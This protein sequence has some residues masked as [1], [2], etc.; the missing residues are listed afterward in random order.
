V[1][2]YV[3][4]F[5]LVSAALIATDRRTAE[6]LPNTRDQDRWSGR[7]SQ[8]GAGYTLAGFSGGAYLLGKATGNRHIQEAGWLAIEAIAHTQVVIFGV[9][10]ITNRK[11][12]ADQGKGA[13]W[14]G[15]SSFPSGH[16]AT[17][18][19]VASVFAYEYRH[20][21]AVPIVAYGLASA[22]AASRVSAQRHFASDI[23]VGGATG[24][25]LGR[26]VYK[27]H[28]NASLP[29]SPVSRTTPNVSFTGRGAALEW[30]F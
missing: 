22:I 13:F 8:L 24:F 25:L 16:A 14:N 18:F 17:S 9:K 2:K 19:A 12:P 1:K 7:V 29:G 23:F 6:V 30:R 15:G 20:H 11:R 28:H 27:R 26:F 4:P 21:I 3:I 10:Q 5:A